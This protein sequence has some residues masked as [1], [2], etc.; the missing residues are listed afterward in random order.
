MTARLP[1]PPQIITYDH[2]EEVTP[3]VRVCPDCTGESMVLDNDVPAPEAPNQAWAMLSCRG[4]ADWRLW[5]WCRV[6]GEVTRP[7]AGK[8]LYHERRKVKR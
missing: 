1:P 7:D 5:R 6:L 8:R 2:R 4:T 3:V